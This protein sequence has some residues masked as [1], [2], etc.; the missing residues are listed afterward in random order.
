MAPRQ[1]MIKHLAPQLQYQKGEGDLVVLKV[2]IVGETDGDPTRLIFD[3]I[4]LYDPQT[5]MSAMARTTGYTCSILSQM[6]GSRL[7]NERGVF[8]PERNVPFE[9]F[10]QELSKRKIVINETTTTTRTLPHRRIV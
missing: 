10:F 5:G 9:P 2:E 8:T 6:V 3:L 7:V 1:F 4:D